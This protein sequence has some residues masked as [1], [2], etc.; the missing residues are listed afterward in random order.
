M[1]T[2]QC[3]RKRSVSK[4]AVASATPAGLGGSQ[5][6]AAPHGV[7]PSFDSPGGRVPFDLE[8]SWS[9]VDGAVQAVVRGTAN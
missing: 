5:R 3:N 9:H 1:R 7:D 2:L 4:L 6:L 8:A